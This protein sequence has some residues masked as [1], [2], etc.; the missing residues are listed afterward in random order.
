MCPFCCSATE[1]HTRALRWLGCY[2]LHS[3]KK[4]MW[5]QADLSRGLEVF[6]DASFTGNWDKKDAQTGDRDTA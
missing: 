5:F 3:R 6:V 4:G 1:S 2:L